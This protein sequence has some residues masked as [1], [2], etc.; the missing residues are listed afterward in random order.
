VVLQQNQKILYLYI[1]NDLPCQVHV[2]DLS[3][4]PLTYDKDIPG[5]KRIEIRIG[6][7]VLADSCQIAVEL[8]TEPNRTK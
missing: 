5:L 6:Q 1:Q 4:P 8:T 7:E 3:P 2:I